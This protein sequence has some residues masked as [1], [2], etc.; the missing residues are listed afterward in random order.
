MKNSIKDKMLE[1]MVES[2]QITI[3]TIKIGEKIWRI[4]IMKD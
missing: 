4:K 3:K 1:A 2:I